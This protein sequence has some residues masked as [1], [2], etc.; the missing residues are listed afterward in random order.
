[1]T[2]S[3]R[4]YR[5]EASNGGAVDA[6]AG[7][8]E[9]PMSRAGPGRATVRLAFVRLPA[10]SRRAGPPIVFLNGGPGLSGIRFG[11]GRLF[12]LFDALRAAGDVV[13][14]D[15]RGAGDSTPSLACAEPLALALDRAFS[16]DDVLRARIDSTRRCAERL[17]QSAID[18]SAFNTNESADDVAALA[19]AL[20]AE[21]I[22]LLGWS[23]GTHLAFAVLRRHEGLVA[24]AVLA[25]PEGPDHTYKLPSRIQR[26]LETI[27]ERARATAPRAPDLV[28]TM[29]RVLETVA[30][31]PARV[32]LPFPGGETQ[33]AAFGRFDLERMTAEGIADTRVLARLPRWYAAM[34]RG[35]FDDVARDTVLRSYFEELRTGRNGS[36]V[37]ACMD[38]ASGVSQARWRRIEREATTTLLGRAIDF[39][40]PE[41]C[42]AIGRPDLGDAFRAPIHSRA[43]T[44]FITGTLDARTPTDNVDDLAPGFPSH[45]HLV[46]EDAGHADLLLPAGVQ[47]SIVRFLEHGEIE[48]ERERVEVPLRFEPAKPVL[49]YDGECGFCRRRVEGLRAR[50]GDA[51]AFEPYQ[52]A[53]G[54]DIPEADLVRAVHFVD[55]N[56][57]VSSGAEAVLRARAAGGRRGALLW[58]YGRVPGFA[59]VAEWGY[60]W[61]ARNRGRL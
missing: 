28:E 52:R 32:L 40:F 39:P 35:D 16:R 41:L 56:G 44:L 11:R 30:R 58:M 29:R 1:M 25:G 8:L 27:A 7:T 18:L 15:Q 26:Q 48:R 12:G 59:R 14:L 17:E 46:V 55:G 43:E 34:S 37:H 60:R 31:E 33:P 36:L 13:L 4:P 9:V 38:C 61:V 51:V 6:E 19:Q 47:R 49:L 10:T 24:R 2:L 45:R 23:Y 53:T 5:F 21:T 20:G 22:S 50:V 57:E 3:L 42:E 54:L